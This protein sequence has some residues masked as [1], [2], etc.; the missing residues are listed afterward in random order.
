MIKRYDRAQTP[1]QRLLASGVLSEA[2]RQG[3]EREFV[4]INPATL[5]RQIDR[6]LEALWKPRETHETRKQVHCG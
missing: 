1:Y 3:L 2:E 6:T 4:A 5:A